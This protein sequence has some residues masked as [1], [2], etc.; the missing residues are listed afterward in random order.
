MTRLTPS[1]AL[2]LAALLCSGGS[3]RAEDPGQVINLDLRTGK[4]YGRNHDSLTFEGENLVLG[5]SQGV[6]FDR[7]NV[8]VEAVQVDVVADDESADFLVLVED[9]EH[10]QERGSALGGVF[11]L[12]DIS[13]NWI[14]VHQSV[15]AT[16]VCLGAGATGLR[17]KSVR[18]RVRG[19]GQPPDPTPSISFAGWDAQGIRQVKPEGMAAG[20]GLP[21]GK[22]RIFIAPAD[23]NAIA[24]ADWQKW[25]WK[26]YGPFDLAGGARYTVDLD[27]SLGAPSGTGVAA[28]QTQ[29]R[30]VNTH[31]NR[32]YAFY[33]LPA[34][35][36]TPPAGPKAAP[37][38]IDLGSGV[39]L[40]LV[41]I[42]AG[43]FRMGSGFKDD[44]DA[45]PV[46]EVTITR[47]FY[48]GK[49]EVTQEQ[50]QAVTG[51]D[52]SRY[53]GGQNPVEQVS[54]EDCQEF[55]KQL[56]ERIPG[57]GFRLPTEAEWE[58]ASRAGSTTAY[59]FGDEASELGEYAWYDANSDRATHPV[60][61][62]KPNRW[63]LYDMHGNV[64][65]W[66]SD[67]WS[68]SYYAKCAKAAS[69]VQ[70]PSG[71]PSG[72]SRVVR[73]GGWLFDAQN[74]RAASRC[75]YSADHRFSLVGFRIARSQ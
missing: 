35:G 11:R 29:L 50:W 63:G 38:S 17:L 39:N 43:S 23:G 3:L 55:L 32:W 62:K 52:P 37:V 13:P 48:L 65:E 67:W 12:S 61:Q 68:T 70:D 28:G 30:F 10:R 15:P 19:G 40:N 27:G 71:P 7:M 8:I 46:H 64:C 16:R 42:P 6:R 25:A 60:G 26:G 31:P 2:L 33:V 20:E 54:W 73:G 36:P 1:G 45:N 41:P 5:P 4:A 14:P 72:S 18:L 56:N 51:K 75:S 49:Y 53:K 9:V 34:S 66:C 21:P 44:Q 47:P 69:G 22:Y 58:Y 57:G 59:C 24:S 74:T